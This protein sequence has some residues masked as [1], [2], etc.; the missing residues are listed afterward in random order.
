RVLAEAEEA[1]DDARA[2]HGGMPGSLRVTSTVEYAL[3]IVAP[4]VS[5]FMSAHPA[6]RVRLETHTSR[7]DL[8]R[9]RFDVAIRLGR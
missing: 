6:L 5:E 8:V 3:R 1:I 9:E 7:A 4:A 2:E